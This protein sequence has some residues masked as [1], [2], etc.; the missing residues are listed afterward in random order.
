MLK[1]TIKQKGVVGVRK[2][3]VVIVRPPLPNGIIK[4]P[5]WSAA[6]ARIEQ[7][8][9]RTW[10]A[11]GGAPGASAGKI[12]PLGSGYYR[13]YTHGRIYYRPDH[14]A[15]HVYGAIGDRYMQLGG[16]QSWL[17]W[18]TS[19]EQDFAENGRASTFEHGAI[20]WWPDTGAIE[21]GNIAVRYTGLLCFGETDNDGQSASDEPYVIFGIVPAL[22]TEAAAAQTGIYEGVDAGDSRIDNIELY[23]GLPYGLSLSV[24]LMEH[25][26]GDPNQYREAVGQGVEKGGHAVAAATTAIPVIGPAVALAVEALLAE[27]GDDIA[28]A[29]NDLFG[30][31]DDRVGTVTFPITAKEMVT[32]ARAGWQDFRGVRFNL[33]SPLI[34]GDGATYKICAVVEAV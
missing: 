15:F 21:L 1:N 2:E 26:Y 7:E 8:F 5:S 18:P 12:T 10:D 11:L 24:T 23:R 30:T 33:Q 16:P 13:Q 3:Q 20:Y 4:P 22:A 31:E 9:K 29:I 6:W 34:S 28:Q 19:N 14:G 27:F 17:G 32:L 25:D